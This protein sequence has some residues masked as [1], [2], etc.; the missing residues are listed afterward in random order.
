M[1]RGADRGM[2]TSRGRHGP[3]STV[4]VRARATRSARVAPPVGCTR[5]PVAPP[6]AGALVSGSAWQPLM[7][8]FV[9]RWGRNRHGQFG[10]GTTTDRRA[11][12][13]VA[14]TPGFVAL[15]AGSAR[16]GGAPTGAPEGWASGRAARPRRVRRRRR[17]GRAGRRGHPGR[18]C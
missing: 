17:I 16:A 7:P 10:D 15:G 1:E 14:G 9:N 11:P 13:R 12:A 2:A 6:G 18:L 4:V 3:A 8:T 5:A